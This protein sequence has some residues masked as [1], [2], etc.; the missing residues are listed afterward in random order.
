MPRWVS[1]T[2]QVRFLSIVSAW[3]AES[4]M[5]SVIRAVPGSEV[6]PLGVA[7]GSVGPALVEG[8]GAAIG[9]PVVL[10]IAYPPSRPRMATTA[11]APIISSSRRRSAFGSASRS[12]SSTSSSGG[13]SRR[14]P[15]V[16]G[17]KVVSSGSRSAWLRLRSRARLRMVVSS[18]SPRSVVASSPDSGERIAV[19]S[20]RYSGGGTSSGSAAAVSSAPAA[21]SGSA[22][23]VGVDVRRRGRRPGPQPAHRRRRSR[24]DGR[25]DS[26][27]ASAGR[28]RAVAWTA[29]GRT[30]RRGSPAPRRMTAPRARRVEVGTPRARQTSCG[31]LL[32]LR[33]C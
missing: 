14:P 19:D 27:V 24:P 21:S 26:L 11:T 7:P 25:P 28:R 9:W 17:S 8:P 31:L 20:S 30:A 13:G 32:L 1:A 12:S 29:V 15:A 5:S 6:S 23:G 22:L 2:F 10:M 4:I 16:R 18:E 3:A 33:R